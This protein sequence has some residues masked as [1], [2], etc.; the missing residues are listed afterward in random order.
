MKKGS[1]KK[2][3]IFVMQSYSNV[4]IVEFSTFRIKTFR[5]KM[6][7]IDEKEIVDINKNNSLNRLLNKVNK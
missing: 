5:K 6:L 4:K 7:I 3:Q 2:F 1:G